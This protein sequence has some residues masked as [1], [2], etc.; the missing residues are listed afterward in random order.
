MQLADPVRQETTT[1]SPSAFIGGTGTAPA[2]ERRGAV[3]PWPLLAFV[4]M[5]LGS[6]VAGMMNMYMYKH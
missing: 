6:T 4:V 2:I 1:L 5:G 3:S